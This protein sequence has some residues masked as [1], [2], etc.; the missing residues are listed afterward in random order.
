MPS[1]VFAASSVLDQPVFSTKRPLLPTALEMLRSRYVEDFNTKL[2]RVDATHCGPSIRHSI[3]PV[4]L[5]QHTNQ[6]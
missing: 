5:C 2:G 1:A 4:L 6:H 3:N